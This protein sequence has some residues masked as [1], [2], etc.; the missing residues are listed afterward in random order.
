MIDV[1]KGPTGPANP[2]DFIF[3]FQTLVGLR[4]D[5]P[6]SKFNRISAS[7]EKA[8]P[9]KN[10]KR[11]TAG[12]MKRKPHRVQQHQHLRQEIDVDT[13]PWTLWLA[14]E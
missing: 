5:I 14:L 7:P 13:G 11:N 9:G 3:K 4:N 2:G 6:S 8:L 10:G 1:D 12:H